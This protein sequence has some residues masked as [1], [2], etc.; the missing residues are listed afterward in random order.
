MFLSNLVNT[1]Y[2]FAANCFHDDFREKL[3]QAEKR[4]ELATAAL[5]TANPLTPFDL[6]T[7]LLANLSSDEPPWTPQDLDRACN[8]PIPAG[9]LPNF[10]QT[11][12]VV[13]RGALG[14][15]VEQASPAC[16]AA[17]VAGAWNAIKTPGKHF[18]VAWLVLIQSN[19][20]C[21]DSVQC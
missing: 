12:T 2:L 5:R 4:L 19:K 3:A 21:M 6:P 20:G 15:W 7:A 9:H 16:G 13:S 11:E 14:G 8:N 17:S 18:L 10:T 1:V